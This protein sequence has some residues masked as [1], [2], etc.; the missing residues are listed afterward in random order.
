MIE[1]YLYA[2]ANND[3]QDA[4]QL[5]HPD[6]EEYY[7]QTGERFSGRETAIEVL[8]AYPGLPTGEVI[9]VSGGDRGQAKV[10]RALPMGPAVI[11][12]FGG[13]DAFTAELVLDYPGAGR[14]HLVV[15]GRV[16]DGLIRRTRIYWAAPDE[17][18]EWR[19]PFVEMVPN[20]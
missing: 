9:G 3:Y 1:R 14:Y 13:D 2:L 15:I 12:V 10:T 8:K 7:P 4:E 6:Y 18:A 5:I 20:H 17:P 16:E 11:T 19:A